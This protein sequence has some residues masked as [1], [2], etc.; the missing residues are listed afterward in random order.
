MSSSI[1]NK[2]ICNDY[3]D[4]SGKHIPKYKFKQLQKSLINKERKY[5]CVRHLD[6]SNTNIIIDDI[7]PKLFEIVN[8]IM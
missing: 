5:M 6:I 4:L 1:I 8:V 2:Y 3:I 7:D